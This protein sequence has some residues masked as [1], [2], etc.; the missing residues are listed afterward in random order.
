MLK[1]MRERTIRFVGSYVF[2]LKLGDGAV[3]LEGLLDRPFKPKKP[4][5][6][7]I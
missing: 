1:S 2:V 6:R 3:R 5:L 4:D 7:V